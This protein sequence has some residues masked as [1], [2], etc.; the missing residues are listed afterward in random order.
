MLTKLQ[1]KKLLKLARNSIVSW[2]EKKELNFD[3]EKKK[4]IQKRGIF[5]TLKKDGDLRGCI[6]YPYPVLPLAEAVFQ[7]ARA[8]AFNDP[9]F[10]PVEKEEL[11]DITIEISVL[12]VPKEIIFKDERIFDE[13][14]T[15]RD[16][17]IIQDGSYSG[18]LLPQVAEEYQWSSLQFL[19]AC[20]QK[21]C[22]PNKAWQDP[23][24]KIFK[25]QAQIFS[26]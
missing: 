23:L 24:C 17:L 13:I 19:E 11:K 22:L 2:L 16:G 7:A 10:E 21:A 15:G 5:V 3:K 18:L 8:A 1:G 14:V 26:E 9:R 6:G 12:T 4:F 25:F 20:C